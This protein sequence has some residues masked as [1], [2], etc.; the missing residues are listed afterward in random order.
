[1]ITIQNTKVPQLYNK[2][3]SKKDKKTYGPELHRRPLPGGGFRGEQ[4]CFSMSSI[5]GQVDSGTQTRKGSGH[6]GAWLGLPG[7][8][9]E[10]AAPA[11]SPVSTMDSA[12]ARPRAVHLG[13]SGLC[14]FAGPKRPG[15][16]P[17]PTVG[18]L[19]RKPQSG[20]EDGGWR[21]PR[22][23]CTPASATVF[24]QRAPTSF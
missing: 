14:G 23:R 4:R 12:R 13:A 20:R 17:D 1:M 16:L 8:L 9:T 18:A 11:R 10:R 3:S 15:R 6:R 22:F 19:P 2:D 21:G 7:S 24:T 5:A